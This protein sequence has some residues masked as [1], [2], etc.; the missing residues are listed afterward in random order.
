[1]ETKHATSR[2]YYAYDTSS[3]P[4][5]RFDQYY[6]IV[7]NFTLQ[8]LGIMPPIGV[9]FYNSSVLQGS[10]LYTQLGKP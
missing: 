10:A 5:N 1:M 6:Q 9:N 3:Y 2:K 4:L 7:C 8:Y